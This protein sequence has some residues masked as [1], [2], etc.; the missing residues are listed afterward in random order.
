MPFAWIFFGGCGSTPRIE[1]FGRRQTLPE[2]RRA[3]FHGV[4]CFMQLA[5]RITL[6][7]KIFATPE[8][9]QR[10][11]AYSTSQIAALSWRGRT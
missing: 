5:D 1:Q 9:K 2:L 8:V 11:F 3:G 10:H 6:V 7:E 4:H